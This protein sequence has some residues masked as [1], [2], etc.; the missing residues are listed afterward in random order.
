MDFIDIGLYAG[1]ALVG[2]CALA[3][4]V[5]PLVQSFDDPKKL[6]KSGIGVAALVVIF[7]ISYAMA[8]GSTAETTET[9]SKMVGAGLFTTYVFFFGAIV[10]IVYTEISKIIN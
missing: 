1:Y 2:L 9:T 6:V 7:F 10:G 8:D 5:I 3:A 4:I